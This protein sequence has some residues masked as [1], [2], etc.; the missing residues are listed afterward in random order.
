[1]V[2][3]YPSYIDGTYCETNREST[4]E[5]SAAANRATSPLPKILNRIPFKVNILILLFLSFSNE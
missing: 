4:S 3:M 1:M 5:P 2:A